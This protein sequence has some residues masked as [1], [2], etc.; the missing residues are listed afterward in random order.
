MFHILGFSAKLYDAYP[1]GN[2]YTQYNG[3]QYLS[4]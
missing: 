1:K 2:P 3:E 4:S